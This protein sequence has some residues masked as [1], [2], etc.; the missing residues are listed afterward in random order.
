MGP[1]EIAERWVEMYNDVEPG[2]YGTDRFLELCADDVRWR[3][4]PTTLTPQ[5]RGGGLAELREA[6]AFG[7]SLFVDRRVEL[8]ELVAD[9][10]R[11]ALRCTWSATTKADLGPDAPP[12]GTRLT[13]DLA[14]F[15]RV[16]D[17]K[18]TELRE[19]LSAPSI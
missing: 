15:M 1:A 10:E 8:K 13:I 3:E 16:I 5:G 7:A 2:S 14:S 11:A 6:V 12:P 9:G 17:G 19:V 4:S 18:I